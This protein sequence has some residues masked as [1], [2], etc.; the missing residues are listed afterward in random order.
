MADYERRK[1]KERM[2]AG[3]AIGAE[4]TNRG[5]AGLHTPAMS[6]TGRTSEKL[7][8]KVGVSAR[9]LR[10]R[11]IAAALLRHQRYR[12]TVNPSPT[13]KPPVGG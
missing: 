1:A 11:G 8:E 4:I 6:N 2:A 12:V 3:G 7:A 13:K 10:R 9:T 5:S